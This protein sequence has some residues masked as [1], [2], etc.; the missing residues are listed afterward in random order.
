M[1]LAVI[2]YV[3]AVAWRGY[4]ETR[5]RIPRPMDFQVPIFYGGIL[6]LTIIVISNRNPTFYCITT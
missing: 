5:Q 2:V 6:T 3:F 1:L 4:G